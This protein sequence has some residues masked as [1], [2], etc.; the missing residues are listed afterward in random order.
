MGHWQPLPDAF[1]CRPEAKKRRVATRPYSG[2]HP[3]IASIHRTAPLREGD[4]YV[5][6]DS[7][8]L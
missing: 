1:R 4:I 5:P 8:C 3:A 6:H 2:Y 7:G